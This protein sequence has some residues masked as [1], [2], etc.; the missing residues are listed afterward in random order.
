[1]HPTVY[2]ETSS[3]LWSCN[4]GQWRECTLSVGSGRWVPI[5][6]PL[7]NGYRMV[8]KFFGLSKSQFLFSKLRRDLLLPRMALLWRLH[9]EKIKISLKCWAKWLPLLMLPLSLPLRFFIL[10]SK[11]SPFAQ[12]FLTDIIFALV[13]MERC[14]FLLPLLLAVEHLSGHWPLTSP[15][16]SSQPLSAMGNTAAKWII[17]P[18]RIHA[19]GRILL[20]YCH[21]VSMRSFTFVHSA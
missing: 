12:C 21:W 11:S 4:S 17:C 5:L 7:F 15:V 1:M 9:K 20:F 10:R 14:S 8:G 19:A 3:T 2:S 13:F 18:L 6:T 16:D